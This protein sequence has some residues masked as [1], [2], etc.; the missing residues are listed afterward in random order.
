MSHRPN[1]HNIG[2]NWAG[3]LFD[4]NEIRTPTNH[5]AIVFQRGRYAAPCRDFFDVQRAGGTWLLQIMLFPHAMTVPTARVSVWRGSRG[6][7]QLWRV[8]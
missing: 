4:H 6:L 8:D 2:P 7:E 5:G 3:R 1:R